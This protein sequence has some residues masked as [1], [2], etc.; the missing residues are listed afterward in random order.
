MDPAAAGVFYTSPVRFATF[1]EDSGTTNTSTVRCESNGLFLVQRSG[2]M[3][4]L[5]ITP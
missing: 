2:A 5:N 3:A 4:T 1:E